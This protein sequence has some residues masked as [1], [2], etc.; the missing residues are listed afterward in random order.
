[1]SCRVAAM[2]AENAEN[3]DR[4]AVGLL[5]SL[6]LPVVIVAAT[7]DFLCSPPWNQQLHHLIPGSKFVLVEN[8][9]HFPWFE[10]PSQFWSGLTG[11]LE[12]LEASAGGD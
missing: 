11:A 10:N 12:A 2:V 1:M 3:L 6:D 4:S 9:G 5:P 8:A 7:D